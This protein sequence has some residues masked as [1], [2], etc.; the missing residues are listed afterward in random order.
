MATTLPA[1]GAQISFGRVHNAYT[2][3]PPTQFTQAGRAGGNAPT[4]GFN[5]K[6]SSVLGANAAYGIN[7]T[8]GTQISFSAK[9]GGKPYPYTY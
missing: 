5:I 6:L 7:Q 1:T 8:A 3:N 4:G 9:F 2:N